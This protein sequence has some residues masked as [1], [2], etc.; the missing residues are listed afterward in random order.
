[1]TVGERIR[2]IR[3]EKGLTQ[4]QLSEKSGVAA[5]SIHQYETGK[6]TPRLEQLIYIAS[7]LEIDPSEFAAF[8][9]DDEQ[10]KIIVKHMKENLKNTE[11]FIKMS[12]AEA[13]R[14]GFLQFHSEEDRIV[15][16]YQKLTDEGRIAAGGCFFQNLDKAA[17]SK[18]ADYVMNLSENPLY[19]RTDAPQPTLT[20]QEVS[21]TPAP[22]SSTEGPQEPP[23]GE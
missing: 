21:D 9:S 8:V 20:A 4:A 16:F 18:V 2:E 17:L 19:Q 5:I 23:E 15:Y 12:D 14:A 1:M 11:Q 3:K 22:E 13:Y 6:R 10:G 7:A